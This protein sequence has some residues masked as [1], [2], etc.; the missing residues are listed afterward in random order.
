MVSDG[1][2]LTALLVESMAGEFFCQAAGGGAGEGALGGGFWG[3]WRGAG[4]FPWFL[5]F[6]SFCA[7]FLMFLWIVSVLL[8][9]VGFREPRSVAVTC[10]FVW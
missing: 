1:A 3:F 7:F 9:F 8:L 2:E 4:S 10:F 5:L 6:A